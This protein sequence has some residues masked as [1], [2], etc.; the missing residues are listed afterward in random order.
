MGCT[1]LS[2]NAAALGDWHPLCDP[3]E[4]FNLEPSARGPSSLLVWYSVLR[5]YPWAIH[6]RALCALLA[7]SPGGG[8]REVKIAKLMELG[9]TQAQA[10]E[11][12]MLTDWNEEQAAGLL[13]QGL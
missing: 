8:A 1:W 13:F 3:E 5:M 6:V 12:L 2:L 11:A 10:T 4:A 7:L 9:F